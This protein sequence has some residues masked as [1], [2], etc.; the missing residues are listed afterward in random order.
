ML[1]PISLKYGTQ[2]PYK[3]LLTDQGFSENWRMTAI[4]YMGE[5]VNVATLTHSDISKASDA[6][7]NLW[8][9]VTRCSTAALLLLQ[10]VAHSHCVRR[11]GIPRQPQHSRVGGD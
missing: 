10:Q 8:N 7:V 4:R 5:G 2:N 9:Y 11:I 6:D 3:N 1:Q